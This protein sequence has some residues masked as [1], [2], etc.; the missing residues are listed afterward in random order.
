[1]AKIGALVVDL[2]ADTASFNA[3]VQKAAANL[4]THALKM[5]RAIQGIQTRIDGLKNAGQALAGVLA[6]RELTGAIGRAL[7]YAA[8]LGEVSQQI[9]VTVKD[10]QTYRYIGTQ[11]NITQEEMEKALAKLSVTAGQAAL[12]LQAPQK[13]FTALGISVRDSAGNVKTA[14][15]LIP[16]IAA[17]LATITD[18][19]QRAAAEV[20]LFGRAGQKLDPL[21]TQGAAGIKAFTDR[22]EQ[23]GIVLSDDLANN[24]DK[25]ADRI[26]ELKMQLDANFARQVANNADAII[27]LANAIAYMTSKAVDWISKYPAFAGATAGAVAGS[28]LGPWGAA[29]GAGAGFI[30]GDKIS[31]EVALANNDKNFRYGELKRAYA[32]LK[33]A[34]QREKAGG[35]DKIDRRFAG[36]H[37]PLFAAE[38]EFKTQTAAFWRAANIASLP[39]ISKSAP[40]ADLADFLA[41][42]GGGGKTPKKSAE[43]KLS[44]AFDKQL[45][46][47]QE[48]LKINEA[49]AAGDTF[50]ATLL[51]NEAQWTDRL[52]GLDSGRLATLTEINTQLAAQAAHTDA[53]REMVKSAGDVK[54][55]VAVDDVAL[56]A[57]LKKIAGWNE[58]TA[59]SAAAAWATVAHSIVGA[60]DDAAKGIQSGDFLQTLQGIVDIFLNLGSLG[61]FGGKLAT[62][63]NA[64]RVAGFAGGG[65]TGNGSPSSVAGVVHG[66]EFVFDA[67]ATSRIGAD[68]LERI[69]RGSGFLRGGYSGGRMAASMDGRERTGLAL[70]VVP[71]PLFEVVVDQRS[72]AVAAPMAQRAAGAGASMG[73]ARVAQRRRNM[74]PS[75]NS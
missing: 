6:V 60:F 21:L 29:I 48:Q 53:W 62:S 2:I 20:A 49:I 66:K 73:V 5:T 72:A 30:T 13:A 9:G 55:I 19:A 33:S 11:V 34:Q 26:S 36:A 51:Q 64:S 32:D 69:R 68:N 39:R 70:H 61:L 75:R 28:R 17:K 25:A 52:K 43:D 23:L 50:R 1:M 10:L 59:K 15:Q 18:P 67:A 22:A 8:S 3:N 37:G 47:M 46:S 31:K 40:G 74:I 24:A 45:Q 71:S 27:G 12:G 54:P 56:E 42:G 41:S 57:S 65:Y 38:T 14:G 58:K 63:I 7:D 16:E 35:L 44:D 4:D